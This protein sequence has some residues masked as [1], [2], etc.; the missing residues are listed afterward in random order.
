MAETRSAHLQNE[1]RTTRG[2]YFIDLV[3][4]FAADQGLQILAPK[5]LEHETVRSLEEDGFFSL[6]ARESRERELEA[7]TAGLQRK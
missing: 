7:R 2:R 1:I 6:K 3:K 5:R 4:R